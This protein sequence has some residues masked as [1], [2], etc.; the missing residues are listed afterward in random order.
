MNQRR[1]RRS[2]TGGGNGHKPPPKSLREKPSTPSILQFLKPIVSNFLRRF[3]LVLAWCIRQFGRCIRRS[4]A[5]VFRNRGKLLNVF[6]RTTTL[7]SVG[8]LVYDR[9]YETEATISSPAS[10]PQNPFIFPFTITNNSHLFAIRNVHWSCKYTSLKS[11]EVNFREVNVIQGTRSEITAG[12]TLNIFCDPVGPDSRI[13]RTPRVPKVAEAIVLVGLS[14]DS[15]LLG[16]YLWHRTP[17]PI[18][19]SWFAKASNPQWIRGEL[20]Q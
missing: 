3:V 13:V 5:W 8:Y 18:T 7:L 2:L 10:D 12:R 4:P 20:A 11:D 6:W 14:Y 17:S 16:L 9:L 1:G 19:F 15:D